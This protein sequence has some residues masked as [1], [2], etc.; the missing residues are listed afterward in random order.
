MK[1]L[2]LIACSIISLNSFSKKDYPICEGRENVVTTAINTSDISEPLYQSNGG[3]IYKVIDKYNSES[4]IWISYTENE[5]EVKLQYIIREYIYQN[6]EGNRCIDFYIDGYG[7]TPKFRVH[8]S[9]DHLNLVE[10]KALLTIAKTDYIISH[11]TEAGRRI[12]IFE[13]I[14]R[15]KCLFP[16][17]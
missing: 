5:L 6:L 7:K 2:I 14:Q 13:E 15:Q 12:G 11:G 1:I 9:L 8:P 16:W 10:R 17:P 3:C 4:K